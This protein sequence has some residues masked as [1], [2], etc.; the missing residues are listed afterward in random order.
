MKENVKFF[1][2][3]ICDNI[4]EVSVGKVEHPM[5]KEHSWKNSNFLVGGKYDK[6]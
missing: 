6:R 2:C 4:I 3:P 5:E 1:K